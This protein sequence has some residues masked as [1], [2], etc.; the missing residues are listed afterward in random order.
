MNKAY[1][2]IKRR[3]A[4]GGYRLAEIIKGVKNSYDFHLKRA[5]IE[6]QTEENAKFLNLL[7]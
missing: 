2:I 3:I 6:E 4:L 7:D 1:E 5:K